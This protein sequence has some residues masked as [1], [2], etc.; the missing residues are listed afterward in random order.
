MTNAELR[1][2][3]REWQK[4]L[5]LQDW[6]VNA[7]LGRWEVMEC[8]GRI[9]A[10]LPLKCADM[11]ILDPKDS[12]ARNSPWEYDLEATVIHELLHLHIETFAP[13]DQESPEYRDM[14]QAV[15]LIAQALVALKRRVEKRA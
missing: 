13:R 14:E 8:D 4:R 15:E 6:K 10:A 11:M 5:R 3:C 1:R 2:L 9:R 12:A 7:R